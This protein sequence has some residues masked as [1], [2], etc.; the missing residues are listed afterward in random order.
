MS[1]ESPVSNQD[2]FDYAKQIRNEL[3]A[4]SPTMCMAKWLQSTVTLY[5]GFTH[6]CHHPVA[7]KIDTTRLA[8]NHK[9][10]HNTPIKFVAREEMLKGIQTK[11]CNYCWNI[12]NLGTDHLSD[13]T[14]KSA[15]TWAWKHKDAV[16][17]S[18]I[19]ENIN[20]TYF[21]VAFDSTCNFKCTYCSPDVSSRIMEDVRTHGPYELTNHKMHDLSYLAQLD[22]I[23]I[24][25]K[26]YNPYVEAFWKWWPELYSSL[27][28][29]RI[30]GGEPLLSTHTWKVLEHIADAPRSDFT[31]AI[32]TNMGVPRKMIDKLIEVT[33]R[34]TPNIKEFQVFTSA[35]AAGEQC[36]YIRDGIVWSE[37]KENCELFLANTHPDTRLGFSVTSNS[38]GVTS[39]TEFLKFI[40]GLRKKFNTDN[41]YNRIPMMISYLRWPNFICLVNLPQDVKVKYAA[42]WL[43]YARSESFENKGYGEIGGIYLEEID[44]LER[45]CEFMMSKNIGE[46]DMSDFYMFYTQYDKRRG[47]D[48]LKTFPELE[49]HWNDCKAVAKKFGKE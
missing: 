38:L 7:H 14:Y 3:N 32:N 12:E 30:T 2:K 13:R 21:E 37:F 48:F 9:E 20:P 17:E 15:N 40:V 5:N 16:L 25:H 42:E 49:G 10:L 29:F 34:I 8:K 45:L 35:E 27:M 18:G 33:N 46:P 44:Q 22:K 11:E 23:P 28:T 39:F 6:S 24:H 26:E 4:I 19:G 41:A 31:L 36:E 43:E 1:D 47:K